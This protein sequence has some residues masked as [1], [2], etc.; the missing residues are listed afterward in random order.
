MTLSTDTLM[1]I[2]AEVER[3][4]KID[5]QATDV[6]INI[7]LKANQEYKNFIKINLKNI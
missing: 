2:K 3:L 4:T 7:E 1:S 6:I 5:P